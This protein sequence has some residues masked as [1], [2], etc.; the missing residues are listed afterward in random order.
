MS[1]RTR[2]M[3]DMKELRRLERICVTEAAHAVMHHERVGLL[4]VAEDC[5]CSADEIEFRA[6]ALKGRIRRFLEGSWIRRH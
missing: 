6:V 2:L 4:K 5:K 3:R 1:E